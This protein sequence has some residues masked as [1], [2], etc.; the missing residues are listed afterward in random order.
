MSY[1]T[2][3]VLSTYP[4]PQQGNPPVA[5]PVQQTYAMP[6]QQM[7]MQPVYVPQQQQGT[8]V[9]I[10]EGPGFNGVGYSRGPVAIVCPSC[11]ASVNTNVS[12]QPGGTAWIWCVGGAAALC[13]VRVPVRPWQSS[14]PPSHTLSSSLSVLVLCCVFWPVACLPLCMPDCQDIVHSCP[15]CGCVV[16]RRD[17]QRA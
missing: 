7:P 17:A 3:P 15:N 10:V 8:T 11:R 14:V 12:L 16:A 13:G 9:V 6:P 5:M 4:P 2:Q 1:P